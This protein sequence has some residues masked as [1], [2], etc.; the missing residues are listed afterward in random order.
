MEKC[1]KILKAVVVV[2]LYGQSADF[3]NLKSICDKYNVNFEDIIGTKKKKNN[4]KKIIV[5]IIFVLIISILTIVIIKQNQADKK[6]ISRQPFS[7][8]V[9]F[10]HILCSVH[11]R[12][13]GSHCLVGFL[14]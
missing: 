2:N 8:F 10:K 14:F 7:V 5:I 12:L 1:D 4:N 11:N 9:L 3:D 13:H 6:N